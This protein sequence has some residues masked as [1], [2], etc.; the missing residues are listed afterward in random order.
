[1][2]QDLYHPIT[3]PETLN[4]KYYLQDPVLELLTWARKDV[5]LGLGF[6]VSDGASC[7]SRVRGKSPARLGGSWGLVLGGSLVAINGLISR[8]TIVISH[9][10]GLITPLITTHEPPSKYSYPT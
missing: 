2:M 6:R 10:R 7:Q 5:S 1:M 8:V 4:P 9:I 3:T